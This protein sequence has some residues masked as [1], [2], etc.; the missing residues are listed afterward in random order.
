MI[1]ILLGVLYDGLPL[2]PLAVAFV[3]T[4]RYQ[5]VADLSLAGSFSVSAGCCAYLMNSGVGPFASIIAGLIVGLLVGAAMGIT[6]NLLQIEPLLSGLIILF[7]TY[8]TSLGITEGTI[9]IDPAQNPLEY[10]FAAEAR[11]DVMASHPFINSIFL[12]TASMAVLFTTLLLASEWG[13]AFKALED[14]KGGRPFLRSLGLS[15]LRLSTMGYAAGGALA[16]VSGILVA[17]RDR[18]TTAS[19]GLET[20]IDI[21]P[22]YLLGVAL[23]ERRPTLAA[24]QEKYLSKPGRISNALRRAWKFIGGIKALPPAFAASLGVLVFFLII[25]SVQRGAYFSWLPRVLVGI[26]L[27]IIL[28]LRPALNGYSRRRRQSRA[29]R[30]AESTDPLE[31]KHL[32][33]SYPTTTGPKQVLRDVGIVVKPREVVLLRGPNGVGKSTFLRALVNRIDCTGE[34]VIPVAADSEVG[35]ERASAVAYVPQNA[36]ENMATTLSIAEQA[37]LATIGSKVSPFR[38]WRRTASE[39]VVALG[40]SDVAPDVSAITQ[41]LSGGQKRRVLLSLLKVRNPRPVVVALDEP[42]NDLD[43]TG[44]SHC[45][46]VIRTLVN[47]GCAVILID[48][49]EQYQPTRVIDIKG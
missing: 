20:L 7:I 9:R 28:G 23:F 49:Q 42:F 15:P 1:T 19:F 38:W 35:K 10:L 26:I 36:E 2:I 17:L 4:L 21:I 47:K 14:L 8:A 3:W 22:A 31:V 46:D 27:I 12:L 29:T 6:V 30:R 44:R 41:W 16:S 39:A 18:Q 11:W 32:S 43:G 5:R 34:F 33:V 24:Y 37:V 13:C 25:N 45:A 40:V 48:H